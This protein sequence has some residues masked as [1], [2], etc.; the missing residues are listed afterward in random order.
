MG[1]RG[2]LLLQKLFSFSG[3]ALSHSAAAAVVLLY[4]IVSKMML[5]AS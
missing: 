3:F 4:H 2:T 1:L 5:D